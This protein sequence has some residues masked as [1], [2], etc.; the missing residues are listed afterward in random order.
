M[1]VTKLY[2]FRI[3]KNKIKR[4]QR[5]LIDKFEKAENRI[6]IKLTKFRECLNQLL[7]ALKTE[8]VKRR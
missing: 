2:E 7:H 8:M 1:L 5:K 6:R 3:L 4:I